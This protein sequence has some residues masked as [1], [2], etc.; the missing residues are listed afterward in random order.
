MVLPDALS[1][2]S[3]KYSDM[4]KLF[5][6]FIKCTIDIFLWLDATWQATRSASVWCFSRWA[7]LLASLCLHFR[8]S[9]A[10]GK[11][12]EGE[13]ENN[14]DFSLAEEIWKDHLPDLF[15][16]LAVFWAVPPFYWWSQI[17]FFFIFPVHMPQHIEGRLNC[18]IFITLLAVLAQYCAWSYSTKRQLLLRRH[19][20]CLLGT[21]SPD[22]S[23]SCGLWINLLV[24]SKRQMQAEGL[25]SSVIQLT[26]VV[27]VVIW[28]CRVAPKRSWSQTTSR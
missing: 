2:I 25:S 4:C 26:N 7:Q 18:P 19:M 15:S 5:L 8:E 11:T 6:D 28:N 9:D 20:P 1:F 17:F 10:T 24:F 13:P 22:S 27:L 21:D 12:S 16:T 3:L 14:W 23:L